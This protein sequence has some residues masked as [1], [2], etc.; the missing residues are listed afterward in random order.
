MSTDTSTMRELTDAEVADTAG[1]TIS[2]FGIRFHFLGGSY[3]TS[4]CA[5]NG[6]NYGCVS[7]V[8]GKWYTSSGVVPR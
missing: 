1:G 8:N 2:I 3:W 7:V 4:V 6:E 5:D